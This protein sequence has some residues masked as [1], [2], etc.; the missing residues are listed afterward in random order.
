MKM[1]I[2]RRLCNVF[3]LLSLV[4]I[5]SILF[6]INS[7]WSSSDLF[8]TNLIPCQSGG[9]NSFEDFSDAVLNLTEQY[10]TVD[11]SLIFFNKENDLLVN[12]DNDFLVTV[13]KF[14]ELTGLSKTQL[15]TVNINQVCYLSELAA[16]TGYNVTEESYNI[17][18]TRTFGT[19]R[20]MIYT[21]TPQIELDL[22]G[23][24]ASINYNNFHVHQYDTELQAEIAYGHYLSSHDV[25]YVIV[26]NFCWVEK[27]MSAVSN[28]ITIN[29]TDYSLGYQ[30]WG[31]EV[32]DVPTYSRYLQD[33]VK[34]E[35]NDITALPEVVVAVLDTGIDTNHPWFINRMLI[36]E[37]GKYIGLDYTNKSS[38]TEY[39][40][41]D[42]V[43]HGTHCAGIICD[44]TLPNVKILPIKFMY[45]D[46]NGNSTGST[47]QAVLAVYEI[48]NLSQYYNIVAINMSFGH[49]V[50]NFLDNIFPNISTANDAGIF[51]VVAAGNESDDANNHSPANK[52]DAITVSAL[53][54]DHNGDISFA[55][56]FSNY[57]NCIDVCAPGTAI[58]S[59]YIH[60]GL[61]YLNGTSMAA[62]HIAAYIALLKS[63]LYHVYDKS[64]IDQILS[65][66]NNSYILDLGDM[67]RDDYYGYGMPIL[68]GAIPDYV[69]LDVISGE[70][71]SVTPSGFN[72]YACNSD[73]TLTFLPNPNYAVSAV[74]IDHVLLPNSRNL[75]QYIF[76]N[77]DTSHVVSV[78]FESLYKT[79][80]VNHYFE[81]I[82]DINSNIPHQYVIQNE[83]LIGKIGEYTNAVARYYPEFIN[84]TFDQKL[85]VYDEDIVI[86]IYYERKIYDYT[87]N[88][89]LEQ[90]YDLNSSRPPNY[91]IFDS[92]ELIGV[93]GSMTQAEVKSYIGFTAQNVEQQI[94]NY[95][96]AVI[97]IYYSRNIY[98]V[99]VNSSELNSLDISGAGEYLFGATVN[100]NPQLYEGYKWINWLI[101]ECDDFKFTQNIKHNLH[102]MQQTFIMPASDVILTA[103]TQKINYYIK[104]NIEGSGSTE[105][106]IF[107]VTY[108]KSLSIK[109]KADDGYILESVIC[110]D[111]NLKI[112]KLDQQE[113][114]YSV[115]LKAIT[116]NHEL[117]ATFVKNE[118][119]DQ[120]GINIVSRL[121]GLALVLLLGILVITLNII[122]RK[123]KIKY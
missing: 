84:R 77:L 32:M 14:L 36:D 26:D 11:N 110:D 105:R 67:G 1:S 102:V 5:C 66:N 89:L 114:N 120:S 60:G 40:F 35:N 53:K 44:M 21:I 3:V 19:K 42:D 118:I 9:L 92:K 33:T 4:L 7:L 109:F 69:T 2:K 100:L 88:Y 119:K 45:Q 50:T 90:I 49:E 65:G 106:N 13:S 38:T 116:S 12:D 115:D 121:I 78:E 72:F 123:R 83:E 68:T 47:V 48:I 43:G 79:Y 111:E 97:N 117:N 76:S 16:Y 108:G 62:P 107:V 71:G 39:D 58:L 29:N 61:E 31:A 10:K 82:Y 70:H 98:R 91:E 27:E 20:L 25:Q 17:I 30:T 54:K 8:S 75:T 52:T 63:D 95:N 122:S 55:S 59:A 18:L 81:S 94:L 51:C 96:H 56:S 24:V 57:G 85:M 103:C 74:Y 23:A 101:T 87:V 46:A 37:N 22:Y 104:V 15:P 86:N 41:E 113:N 80:T 64:E 28:L 34:A 112:T 6:V 73:V 93:A 99:T